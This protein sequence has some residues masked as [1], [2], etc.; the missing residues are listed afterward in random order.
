MSATTTQNDVTNISFLRRS[1]NWLRAFEDAM[2][3]DPTQ[4][5]VDRLNHQVNELKGTVDKL[6]SQ[7]SAGDV[8]RS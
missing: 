2:D 7:L 6:Q 5:S 4:A 3:F 1:W 8:K